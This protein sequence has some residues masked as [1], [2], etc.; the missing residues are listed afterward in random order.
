MPYNL[1]P[2][3]VAEL[4]SHFTY[5]PPKI[6][7]DQPGRYQEIRAKLLESAALICVLAP[8]SREL[9]IALTKLEETCFWANAAIA[10]RE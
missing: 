10:R 9:S 6:D 2:G 3:Q 5:H 7:Q 1:T 8:A 4:E